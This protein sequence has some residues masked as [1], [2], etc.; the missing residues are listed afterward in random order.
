MDKISVIVVLSALH[1]VFIMATIVVLMK[2]RTFS[3]DVLTANEFR[4]V[5]TAGRVRAALH[6][7]DGNM[8]LCL[9]DSRGELRVLLDVDNNDCAGIG[10]Y[11]ENGAP[12]LGMATK[13]KGPHFC[14]FDKNGF[15]RILLN[16][17]EENRSGLAMFDSAGVQRHE[18]AV[19]TTSF[20]NSFIEDEDGKIRNLKKHFTRNIPVLNIRNETGEIIWK[21]P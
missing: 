20:S 7:D 14:I 4:L 21:A 17:D 2:N 13:N 5:D 9:F 10:I 18:I 16:I 8:G 1:S 6:C 19:E 11:D 12:A 15:S 3:H